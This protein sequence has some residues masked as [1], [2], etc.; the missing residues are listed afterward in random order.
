MYTPQFVEDA[1]LRESDACPP[2]LPAEHAYNGTALETYPR[3][4]VGE[5][6]DWSEPDP[7]APHEAV[8]PGCRLVSNAVLVARGECG[9][10]DA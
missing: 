6:L 8:C 5:W 2:Y 7:V 3:I 9:N 10:C 4:Y 1:G